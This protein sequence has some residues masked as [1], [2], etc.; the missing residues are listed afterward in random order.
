MFF[1]FPV[2]FFTLLSVLA[3]AAFGV[4]AQLSSKTARSALNTRTASIG[5]VTTVHIMDNSSSP[6]Q[7]VTISVQADTQ[8]VENSFDFSVNFDTAVVDN[9]IA[10][11]GADT[12]IGTLTTDNSVPGSLGVH[13]NL[14]AG[15]P[16]DAGTKEIVTIT[17]DVLPSAVQGDSPLTFGDDPMVRTIQDTEST[18]MAGSYDDGVLTV[19]GPTAGGAVVS[20]YVLT[21][22]GAG[23]SRA[24]IT[25]T[26]LNGETRFT[27]TNQFGAYS[28]EDVPVGEV[29]VL[30]VYHNR[31]FFR[32]QTLVVNVGDNVS[33]CNFYGGIW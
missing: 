19:L 28:F 31:Y 12:Q 18:V 4:S 24:L 1:K 26:D 22:S 21:P 20:G 8:G 14:P 29:Y 15:I 13:I 6:S 23:I 25:L 33:D 7:Q 10:Q 30:T 3:M 27:V 32:Q 2:R 9:P 16:L 5:T 11:Y 17:F